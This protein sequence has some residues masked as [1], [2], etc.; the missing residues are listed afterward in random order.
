[1]VLQGKAG[2]IFPHTASDAEVAKP[3]FVAK[4]A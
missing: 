3:V 4:L 1:M 2:V